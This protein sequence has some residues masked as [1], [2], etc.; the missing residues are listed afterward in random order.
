M[1][2]IYYNGCV[3]FKQKTKE[4]LGKLCFRFGKGFGKIA[5]Y[6]IR[7]SLIRQAKYWFPFWFTEPKT[8]T[9]SVKKKKSTHKLPEN[10]VLD[11]SADE[12]PSGGISNCLTK[13]P[14]CLHSNLS[15]PT[16]VYRWSAQKR[17]RPI[18]GTGLSQERNWHK[19]TKCRRP[20][21]EPAELRTRILSPEY[22]HHARIRPNSR[23]GPTQA[24]VT[25]GPC[26][27]AVELISWTCLAP[28]EP[29]LS[30]PKP[31]HTTG[32]S[33]R[34]AR[35]GGGAWSG[36]TARQQNCAPREQS[37]LALSKASKTR[38]LNVSPEA[39]TSEILCKPMEEQ[40]PR[41][42]TETSPAVGIRQ[43]LDPFGLIG[44]LTGPGGLRPA[45]IC[46]PRL[47]YSGRPH[48][49]FGL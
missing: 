33:R 25:P 47:R 22:K 10:S 40:N 34:G 46:C 31:G 28:V 1:C 11:D 20:I 32:G 21:Q 26:I 24:P 9:I 17:I 14:L 48:T 29:N 19:T 37:F 23:N 36:R 6:R 2:P 39:Q 16:L 13:K 43:I 49:P 8:Q 41:L 27:L 35:L 5:I 18:S 45:R 42:T 30:S 38:R 3:S 44:L 12:H 15:N 7:N 4:V